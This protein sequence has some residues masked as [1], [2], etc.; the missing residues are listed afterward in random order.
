MHSFLIWLAILSFMLGVC[1]VRASLNPKRLAK[2]LKKLLICLIP[3][4][5]SNCFIVIFDNYYINYIGYMGYFIG[6]DLMMYE[7]IHFSLEFCSFAFY[8]TRM[9]HVLQALTGLDILLILSSPLGHHVFDMHQVM[10]EEG[11]LYHS[12][13]SNPGHQ[14]HLAFTYILIALIFVI[15]VVRIIKTSR[16]YLERYLTVAAAL[17]AVTCWESFYIFSNTPIDRSMLG[18]AACGI[19]LYYF[20]LEYKPLILTDK[21][22]SKVVST[23]SSAVFFLDVHQNCIYFNESARVLFHLQKDD[24]DEAKRVISLFWEADEYLATDSYSTIK[25]KIINGQSYSFAIEFNK[26]YDHN[27]TYAGSFISIADKTDSLRQIERDRYRATHDALTDLYNREFFIQQCEKR[28][29]ENQNRTY[30]LVCSDIK[31]FKLVNEIFGKNTG[32]QIIINSANTIREVATEDVI[33]GRIGYDQFAILIP[34]DMYHEQD[35]MHAPEKAALSSSDEF[36]YPITVHIGVYEV[37]DIS[38]PVNVMIDRA[39]MAISSIK[40]SGQSHLAYYTNSM[41]DKILWEQQI[42]GQLNGAIQEKMIMPYLHAQVNTEGKVEG[43]EV[44]CRWDRTER[45]LLLPD[46]FIEILERNGLIVKLDQFMW[47]SACQ[48]LRNWNEKELGSLYLSVN[49][50]PKDFYFIDVA[51][52]I[53]NMVKRYKLEPQRLRLEITETSIMKDLKQ[54]LPAIDRLRKAGFIIE[55]D[56]FGSGYSSLNM[57]KDL[58]VDVLKM[59][60]VFLEETKHQDRARTILRYLIEMANSLQIP[61]ITE[62]VEAKEQLD[63]LTSVGCKMFQGFYFS[64]PITVEEFEKTY[65]Q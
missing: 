23:M 35:F 36:Y 54:T 11:M 46:N 64:K 22:L 19:L 57:L 65:L 5:L 16:L 6:T 51:S 4:I 52:T 3:P 62:G 33:Y 7:L 31:D 50:S 2:T 38:L 45:G 44:L 13:V 10:L 28:L 41:R 63:F 12:L 39:C 37:T 49:I 34:K 30:M 53:I 56:D 18:Y 25:K 14:I 59:D 58:P 8:G 32:D 60:M 26:V 55:M 9:R 27:K 15:F 40:H 29:L 20:A 47:E 1:I 43:A 17:F 24:Y 61:V 21:M 42:A 48:I